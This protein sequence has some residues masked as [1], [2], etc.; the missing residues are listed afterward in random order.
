MKSVQENKANRFLVAVIPR[1]GPGQYKWHEMVVVDG[2]FLHGR[3]ETLRMN[4]VH[5]MSNSR[6][7]AI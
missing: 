1:Q 2:A 6:R 3:Y 4:S 7:P 5:V